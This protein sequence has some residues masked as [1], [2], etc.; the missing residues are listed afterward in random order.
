MDFTQLTTFDLI[1]HVRSDCNASEREVALLDR[2][3]GAID[4]I[5]TLVNT[6]GEMRL[7]EFEDGDA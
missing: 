4:E 7:A 6:V 1:E 3:L 2:L 5:N